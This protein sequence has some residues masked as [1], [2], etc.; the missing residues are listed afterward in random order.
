MAQLKWISADQTKTASAGAT[1]SWDIP[2]FGTLD[3]IFLE[4]TNDGAAA[5]AANILLSIDKVLLNVNGE[6]VHSCQL[7]QLYDLYKNSGNNVFQFSEMPNVISLNVGRYMFANTQLRDNF[8]FGKSGINNISLQ[9]ICK[10]GLSGVTHVKTICVRRQFDSQFA[11]S[12]VKCVN[13]PQSFNT[14]GI[15]D[16]DTLPRNSND[17]MITVITDAAGGAISELSC[18]KNGQNI[19]DP[20]SINVLNSVLSARGYQPLSGQAILPICDSS[21]RSV[22]PLLGVA[23]FRV[24]PNFTT[25]PTNGVYNMLAVTV[26]NIPAA[27]LQAAMTDVV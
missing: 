15:D 1:L 8:S 13:Y 22:L 5:T 14:T 19:V 10:S 26:R 24:R 12:F 7:S 9:L 11:G 18:V 3:D 17:A 4:F 20:V 27:M 23:E 2:V 25:A 6:I 21:A 16:V